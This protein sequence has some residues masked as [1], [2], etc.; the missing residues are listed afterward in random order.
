MAN[1]VP[2]FAFAILPAALVTYQ[3]ISIKEDLK[4]LKNQDPV[5]NFIKET[6][7]LVGLHES[8]ISKVDVAVPLILL[9]GVSFGKSTALMGLAYAAGREI[10]TSQSNDEQLVKAGEYFMKFNLVLLGVAAAVSGIKIL[11][12]K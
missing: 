12:G 11:T 10:Y 7:K 1:P 3:S 4:D 5:R 8:S 9:S 6:K 2:D